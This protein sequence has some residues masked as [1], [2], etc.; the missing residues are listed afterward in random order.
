MRLRSRTSE[1]NI[2]KY[3][4]QIAKHAETLKDLIGP[5]YLGDDVGHNFSVVPQKFE[6]PSDV[7]GPVYLTEDARHKYSEFVKQVE[8]RNFPSFILVFTVVLC[9]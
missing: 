2:F 7:R 5:V 6:T 9:T 8:G 4:L 1:N 3:F